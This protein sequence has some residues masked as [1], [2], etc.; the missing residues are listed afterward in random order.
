MAFEKPVPE[1]AA[2][3]VEPPA[4]LK[5]SGFTPGYKPPADYF[6]WFLNSTSQVLKE[7]QEKSLAYLGQNPI[8]TVE[9]DTVENWCAL[10][11]GYA[12]FNADGTVIAKPA[13]YGLL[14]SFC[15]I[16]EVYQIWRTMGNGPTY[17]RSGNVNGWNSTWAKIYDENNRPSIT[18]GEVGRAVAVGCASEGV[19]GWYPV[20]TIPTASKEYYTYN[21]QLSVLGN[22]GRGSGILDIFIRTE[23]TAGQLDLTTSYM[24]FVGKTEG[25]NPAHF[26]IDVSDPEKDATLYIYAPAKYTRYHFSILSE[27]YGSSDGGSGANNFMTLTRNYTETPVLGTNY[28]ESITQTLVAT[29]TTG[30]HADTHAR[31]GADPLTVKDIAFLGLNAVSSTANDTVETWKALGTG[32]A[33]YNAAG[34]INNQP[35]TYGFLRNYINGDEVYQVWNAMP[36]GPTYE[37]SGNV[38]GW[39][40]GWLKNYGEGSK[41]TPDE[42]GAAWSQRS[43]AI[44]SSASHTDGWY[45][46]GTIDISEAY[47]TYTVVLAVLCNGNR[48]SGVLHLSIRTDATAGV[49]NTEVSELVW[50]ARHDGMPETVFAIDASDGEN[51]VLYVYIAENYQTYHVSILAEKSGAE[52]VANTEAKQMLKLT[53][54]HGESSAITMLESITQTI[55]SRDAKTFAPAYE[56][57]QTDLTAGSSPLETGK[58]Y[59]VYE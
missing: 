18:T 31:G 20:G 9:D 22:G 46:V 19:V 1:W 56:Y 14:L 53:R 34:K 11:S 23:A 58:L 12:R 28:V 13:N 38:K 59:L 7:L 41:P 45:K 35:T 32:Y 51:A 52:N 21:V 37:R 44:G 10:G 42:I 36:N 26:A 6:N 50:N 8:T 55:T 54:N 2:A 5:E 48:G 29:S 40:T 25:V 4:S 57:S 16:N 30:S 49:L 47:V 33:Y 27:A 39:A 3:G 24:R 43:V 15:G 17:H